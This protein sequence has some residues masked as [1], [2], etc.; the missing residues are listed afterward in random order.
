MLTSACSAL[1]D[2]GSAAADPAAPEGAESSTVAVAIQ[3]PETPFINPDLPALPDTSDDPPPPVPEGCDKLETLEPDRCGSEPEFRIDPLVGNWRVERVT[4][5]RPDGAK[6]AEDDPGIVG[7]I[8]RMDQTGARF[9]K[10]ASERLQADT[11]VLPDFG[12]TSEI[13]ARTQSGNLYAAAKHWGVAN[14]GGVYKFGCNLGGNWALSELD[15]A[16]QGALI[17]DK[18]VMLVRWHDNQILL[19]RRYSR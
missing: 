1:S 17:L 6:V 13:A 16:E 12:E 8:F 9:L 7:S 3:E 2:A 18:K 15:N 5:D 19:A 10:V 4:Q 11:C 14:P